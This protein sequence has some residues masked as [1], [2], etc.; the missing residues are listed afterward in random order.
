M[1]LFI[2]CHRF[3]IGNDHKR[4]MIDV[5]IIIFL[6]ECQ[7]KMGFMMKESES[8]GC[9]LSLSLALCSLS[10]VC[11]LPGHG[12]R[13]TLADLFGNGAAGQ[14]FGKNADTIGFSA[15]NFQHAFAASSDE[16][17]GM[18]ELLGFGEAVEIG[19]LIVGA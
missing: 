2:C 19:Y 18:W 5:K 10:C 8:G 3:V 16:D 14:G 15:C 4:V 13:Q 17:W 6:P 7:E 11:Y 9:D 1:T 12:C